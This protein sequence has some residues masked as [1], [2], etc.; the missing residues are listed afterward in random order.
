MAWRSAVFG[1][2]IATITMACSRPQATASPEQQPAGPPAAGIYPQGRLELQADPGSTLVKIGGD[3]A[4]TVDEFNDRLREFPIRDEGQDVAVARKQVV[5]Q[6]I[7]A[8]L[9]A[10]EAVR[11]RSSGNRAG[12][13]GTTP[14][15]ERALAQDLIR[16]S[17]ANPNLVGDDEAQSYYEKHRHAFQQLD[18]SSSSN[19]E[20]MLFIKFTLL[21]E[22]FQERI[23]SWRSKQTIEI[24]EDLLK[25]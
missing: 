7:D 23:R 14:A 19:A 18:A 17:V 10:R 3:P 8:K 24:S 11:R 21:S 1:L 22:R 2:L 9:I 13:Q 20:R 12:G 6:M 5:D 15:D 16:T 25:R 4:L